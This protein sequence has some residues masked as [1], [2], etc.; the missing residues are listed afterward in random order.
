MTADVLTMAMDTRCYQGGKNRTKL[1][2]MQTTAVDWF[3]LGFVAL[4]LIA[5]WQVPI[6]IGWTIP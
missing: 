2:R 6:R 5:A 3:A 1:R 4:W